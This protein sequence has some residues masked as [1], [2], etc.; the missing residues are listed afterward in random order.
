M[1]DDSQFRLNSQGDCAYGD[2]CIA[3]SQ[4]VSRCVDQK[5]SSLR[6]ETLDFPAS[7]WWW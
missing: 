6:H 1:L 2:Q 4:E 5:K 7:E 3:L